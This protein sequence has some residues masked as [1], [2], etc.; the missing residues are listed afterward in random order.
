MWSYSL[1]PNLPFLGGEKVFWTIKT[2]LKKEVKGQSFAFPFL[3]ILLHPSGSCPYPR[4]GISTEKPVLTT[5]ALLV[6]LMWE[7]CFPTCCPWWGRPTDD[8]ELAGGRLDLPSKIHRAVGIQ[9]GSTWNP[10]V[11]LPV[12]VSFQSSA[13]SEHLTLLKSPGT[14]TLLGY[15]MWNWGDNI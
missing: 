13:P 15:D 1:A 6:A 5:P 7:G 2:A 9:Q 14:H 12:R 10:A 8:W 3:V 11:Q 4:Q